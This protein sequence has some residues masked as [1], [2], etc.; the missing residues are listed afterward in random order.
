M[1]LL[2]FNRVDYCKHCFWETTTVMIWEAAINHNDT[3]RQCDVYRCPAFCSSQLQTHVFH[4]H[5]PFT[6]FCYVNV[7]F[8][9]YVCLI[10]V[11]QDYTVLGL[12]TRGLC[13]HKIF[14]CNNKFHVDRIICVF[15]Q[16]LPTWQVCHFRQAL[17]AQLLLDSR[18]YHRQFNQCTLPISRPACN[19][20]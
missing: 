17:V 12:A 16:W 5:F 1:L 14:H 15:V 3:G 6:I 8:F 7:I 4:V 9:Y 19:P 18:I 13:R 10:H 11:A 2:E 20:A